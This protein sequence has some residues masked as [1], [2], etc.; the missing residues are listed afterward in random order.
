MAEI[1]I[2]TFTV[3]LSGG[4]FTFVCP[5]CRKRNYHG[6]VEGHRVSHCKCWSSQGYNIMLPDDAAA[7]EG[8]QA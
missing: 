6:A 1:P 2:P 8:G 5:M 3:T 7:I 4:Q